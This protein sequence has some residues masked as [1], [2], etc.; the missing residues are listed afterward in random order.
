MATKTAKNLANLAR[1]RAL[2]GEVEDPSFNHTQVTGWVERARLAV[3][4]VYG[5]GS[6]QLARFDEIRYSPSM[7]TDSTPDSTF[8]NVAVGGARQAAKMLSAVAEDIEHDL[9]G[10]ELP[11]LSTAAMHPW[12]ADAAARLWENGHQQQAVQ[13]AATAVEQ[14]LKLKL[15]AHSGSAAGIVAAAFSSKPAAAGS[16]RLRFRAVGP[17]GSDNWTS[18]H[19][20]AGAFGRGCMLRIRNLYTHD[21]DADRDEQEDLEALAALSLLARW[22]EDAEVEKA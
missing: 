5:A 1:I 17:E 20:G 13:A 16:P 10:P 9:A 14:W 2:V 21:N 22:I 11:H 6:D 7:W 4:A 15:G 8:H 18:A 19:D 3:V 12:V